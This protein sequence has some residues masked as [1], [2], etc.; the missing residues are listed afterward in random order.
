[1]APGCSMMRPMWS[2]TS[3]SGLMMP[4][5]GMWSLLKSFFSRVYSR[6]RMRAMRIGTR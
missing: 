4:S 6:A 5:I 2:V 1:M 3:S